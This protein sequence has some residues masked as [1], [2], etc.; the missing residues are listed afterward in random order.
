MVSKGGSDAK[1][2]THVKKK[3]REKEEEKEARI[4][5][6]VRRVSPSVNKPSSLVV[7]R[8]FRGSYVF[9]SSSVTHLNPDG[10]IVGAY[11][12]RTVANSVGAGAAARG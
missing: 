6:G 10:A 7:E 12:Y 8:I 11:P 5:L 3:K 2:S 1:G 9:V 4:E